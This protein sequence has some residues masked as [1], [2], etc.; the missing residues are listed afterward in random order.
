MHAQMAL[1]RRLCGFALTL[2]VMAQMAPA[3]ADEALAA[4]ATAFDGSIVPLAAAMPIRVRSG[5]A[6][7][8]DIQARATSADTERGAATRRW[9]SVVE[10]DGGTFYHLAITSDGLQMSGSAP[11]DRHGRIGEMTFAEDNAPLTEQEQTTLARVLAAAAEFAYSGTTISKTGDIALPGLDA[12]LKASLPAAAA[13]AVSGL[14]DNRRV[15]GVTSIDG[16]DYLFVHNDASITAAVDGVKLG[17]ELDGYFLIHA[18]S[19]LFAD[20]EIFMTA[21]LDDKPVAVGAE[22]IIC[23]LTKRG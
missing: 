5:Y 2:A 21:T 18:A 15:G 12:L 14:V 16:E 8:C 11:V 22:K 7:A 4:D 20:A 9:T 23:G 13:V 10:R 6:L 3:N 1:A 19:G 17:L